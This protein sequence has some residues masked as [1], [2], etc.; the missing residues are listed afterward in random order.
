LFLHISF[1]SP[2][3]YT[4][5]VPSLSLPIVSGSLCRRSIS[6]WPDYLIAFSYS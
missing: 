4:F 6:K 5:R 1:S 3:V 2:G